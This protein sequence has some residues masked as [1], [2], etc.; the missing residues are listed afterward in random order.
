MREQQDDR[1]LVRV[2]RAEPAPLELSLV[3]GDIA[4]NI[5]SALDH[6]VW[7]LVHRPGAPALTAE[8]ERRV[9]FPFRTE[10]AAFAKLSSG[11]QT[12]LPHVP[13]AVVAEFEALQPYNRKTRP[14]VDLLWFVHELNRLDKHRLLLVVA[15]AQV[16]GHGG[17]PHPTVSLFYATPLTPGQRLD[18]GPYT[19]DGLRVTTFRPYT[20]LIFGSS[21]PAL[22]PA[23]GAFVHQ[24]LA[25]AWHFVA[26]QVL[27]ALSVE[28]AA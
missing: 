16:Q 14:E 18:H 1:P 17:G 26:E 9:G 22:H 15:G 2:V 19:S 28:L 24:V 6:L 7:G 23:E 21:T 4:H 12:T 25:G 27:P 10:P 8:Q 20:K 13:A 11:D 3:V 5:R